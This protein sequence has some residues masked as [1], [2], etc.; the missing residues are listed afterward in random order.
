MTEQLQ[1]Y[2]KKHCPEVPAGFAG[3]PL[4]WR[5]IW[6]HE[7]YQFGKLPKK[8][9]EEVSSFIVEFNTVYKEEHE[10]KKS[11][12]IISIMVPGS[13]GMGN[14]PMYKEYYINEVH[15]MGE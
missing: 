11:N 5:Q 4:A 10:Y 14:E 7:Q 9:M 3:S 12:N 6:L 8:L 1:K 13:D 2:I 15:E